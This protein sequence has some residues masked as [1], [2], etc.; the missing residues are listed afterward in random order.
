[1]KTEHSQ[2][3]DAQM[4]NDRFLLKLAIF[5]NGPGYLTDEQFDAIIQGFAIVAKAALAASR[6]PPLAGPTEQPN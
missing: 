2:V 4:G 3:I 5:P 1:M 6:N